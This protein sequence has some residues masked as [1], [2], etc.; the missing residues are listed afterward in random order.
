MY[1]I[2]GTQ[3]RCTAD[4]IHMHSIMGHKVDV[5]Q[6]VYICTALVGHK[7]GV[8][9]IVYTCT[10]LVEHKVGVQQIVN[11][12]SISRTQGRCT[13]DSKHVQHYWD[14]R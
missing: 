9:Q 2:S 6:I 4:S 10:A 11:M 14:T 13:T 12:Y 5:Q 1:R 8:Q 7:V 3:G